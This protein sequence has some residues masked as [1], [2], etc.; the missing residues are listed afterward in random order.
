MFGVGVSGESGHG[1]VG[2]SGESGHG[3]VGMS[4]ESGHGG[5][6]VSGKSG[7]GGGWGGDSF[8]G[9]GGG[10]RPTKPGKYALKA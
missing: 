1:G 5:V 9:I 6:G 4:G 3:G 10:V 8:I 2:V 7:H